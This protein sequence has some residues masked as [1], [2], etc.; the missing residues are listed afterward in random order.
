MGRWFA[1]NSHG[2]GGEREARGNAMR[3]IYEMGILERHRN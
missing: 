3:F 1:W 2:A